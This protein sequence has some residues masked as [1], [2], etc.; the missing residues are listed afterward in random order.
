MSVSHT[1]GPRENKTQRYISDC[2]EEINKLKEVN[3]ELLA[4]CKAALEK[5]TRL[6]LDQ[7]FSPHRVKLQAAI[8]KAT[9]ES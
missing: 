5:I 7:C 3:A 8:K 1:P 2:H 9:G 4:A 6:E